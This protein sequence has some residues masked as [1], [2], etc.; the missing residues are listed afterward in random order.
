M[1]TRKC[2]AQELLI[3]DN[4]YARVQ[5]SQL[6]LKL[7]RD[8]TSLMII[9]RPIIVITTLTVVKMQHTQPISNCN[10]RSTNQEM[11]GISSIHRV[12]FLIEVMIQNKHRHYNSLS[13][14]SS[15]LESCSW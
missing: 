11:V 7:H 8:K 5:S 14:T 1:L 12:S 9:I 4:G 6:F 13:C 10:T 3:I 2:P 15:H